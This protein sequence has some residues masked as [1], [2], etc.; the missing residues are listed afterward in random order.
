[1]FFTKT[2]IGSSYG[3]NTVNHKWDR[4][5]II[6]NYNFVRKRKSTRYVYLTGSKYCGAEGHL[7]LISCLQDTVINSTPKNG[8]YI[9]KLGLYNQ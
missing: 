2:G 3:S 9:N 6:K 7:K 5:M 8:K 4:D 1:M